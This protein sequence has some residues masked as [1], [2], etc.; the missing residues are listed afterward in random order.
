MP[1]ATTDAAPR[2]TPAELPHSAGIGLKSQHVRD[3]LE[4]RP[5]LGFFEVHAENYMVDGG[6]F[7]HFLGRIREHYPLSLHD[8]GLSI[9]GEAALDE[10]HLD[11]VQTCLKRRLL[12]V[13]IGEIHLA[14]FARDQEAAGAPLLIDH[15]GAPVD[16][17]AGRC[18]G[19]DL[20]ASLVLL[21]L[22]HGAL[23]NVHTQKRSPPP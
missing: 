18:A 13:A 11:R 2:G 8:V 19:I 1:I 6:P 4:S 17:K 23:A 12:L 15:H 22:R 20:P 16:D 7:H 3:V 14:R 21:L 5:A 10:A 9:G